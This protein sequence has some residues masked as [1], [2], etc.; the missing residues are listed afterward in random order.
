M[1]KA[2]AAAAVATPSLKPHYHCLLT[3]RVEL[4]ILT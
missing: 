1:N 2:A 3:L 4:V